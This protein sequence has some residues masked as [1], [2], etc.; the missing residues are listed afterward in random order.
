MEADLKEA[1][2][3]FI[4]PLSRLRCLHHLKKG[5]WKLYFPQGGVFAVPEGSEQSGDWICSHENTQKFP[6]Q[7]SRKIS[8]YW[9]FSLLW[10]SA[11]LTFKSNIW[12]SG[13]GNESF[14]K[15]FPKGPLTLI[16]CFKLLIDCPEPVIFSH[17]WPPNSRA[18]QIPTSP[19]PEIS[20]K[21]VHPLLPTSH[22]SSPEVATLAIILLQHARAQC[23]IYHH[24]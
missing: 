17:P 9:G 18:L 12:F 15:F 4:R 8:G 24:D 2:H 16:L 13:T 10:N 14:F 22:Q 6:L 21:S 1:G 11:T 19:M 3:C 20:H 7:I 5:R 23:S